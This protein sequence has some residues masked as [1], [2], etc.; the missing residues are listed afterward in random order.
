[1]KGMYLN[2]KLKKMM[3][4]GMAAVMTML[5]CAALTG[6]GCENKS[7]TKTAATMDEAVGSENVPAATVAT[8]GETDQAVVDAGLTVN[9]KGDVVDKQGNKVK[10]AADGTIEVKTAEGKTVKVDTNKVK[11]AN[12]NKTKVDQ[13]NA[14]AAEEQKNTYNSSSNGSS[15]STNNSNQNN[16]SSQQSKSNSNGSSQT[17]KANQNTSQ[18][19][20]PSGSNNTSNQTSKPNGNTNVS[21]GGQSNTQQSATTDPHAGKTW[22]DDEYE[23]I[24]HPAVTETVKVVDEPE[25]EETVTKTRKVYVSAICAGC[26]AIMDN[27]SCD[28]MDDHALMHYRNGEANGYYSGFVDEPYEE[29]ITVPEKFHYEEHVVKEEWTEKKLVRKA[30][31][32]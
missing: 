12:E 3:V 27:W 19:S 16:G 7:N 14:E 20:K 29:T 24:K 4:A 8:L 22:H 9:E 31:W 1:M 17:S 2:N 15:N 18:T 25:H 21:G 30:G 10:T 26:G 32:Y 28:E 5:S 11:T 23:Y 6:C 13:A